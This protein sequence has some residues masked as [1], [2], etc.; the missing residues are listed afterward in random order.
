ME[1][2]IPLEKMTTL[3]K[4]RALERIWDDLQRTPEDIPSPS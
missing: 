3:D 2:E 1:V 4:L